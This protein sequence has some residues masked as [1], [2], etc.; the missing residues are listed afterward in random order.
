MHFEGDFLI[1][2]RL[3]FQIFEIVVNYL[4][5]SIKDWWFDVHICSQQ[6]VPTIDTF[7]ST[8]YIE[9]VL[10]GIQLTVY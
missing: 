7:D 5:I 10:T 2:I 1:E 3:K 9:C 8:L 4:F 6:N